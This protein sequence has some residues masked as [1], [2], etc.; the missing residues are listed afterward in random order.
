MKIPKCIAKIFK[1]KKMERKEFI[2]KREQEYIDFVKQAKKDYSFWMKSNK[3]YHYYG[4]NLWDFYNDI[5]GMNV[6][7]VCY[8]L[9][10]YFNYDEI[11]ASIAHPYDEC[12]G[13]YMAFETNGSGSNRITMFT[14]TDNIVIKIA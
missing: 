11:I 4:D 6:Y 12:Y 8:V 5:I 7:E 14:N 1:T 3:S 9:I 13:K 2:E 10:N